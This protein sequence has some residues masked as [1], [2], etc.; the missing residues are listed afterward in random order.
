M[1]GAN[2]AVGPMSALAIVAMGSAVLRHEQEC[3]P[4]VGGDFG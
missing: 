2:T 3:E 1:A 4:E